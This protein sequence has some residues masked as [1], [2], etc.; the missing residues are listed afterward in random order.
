MSALLRF[1]NKLGKIIHS[2]RH[3]T[4]EIVV[5]EFIRADRCGTLVAVQLKPDLVFAVHCALA[6]QAIALGLICCHDPSGRKLEA[7]PGIEPGL[8]SGA[9]LH[10]VAIPPP[11]HRAGGRD[12]T[13]VS[14][15]D[16]CAL[17]LSYARNI[18]DNNDHPWIV[19]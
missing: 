8:M 14:A 19:C 15:L 5:A 11:G 17:P 10:R 7:Q 2:H 6:T 18:Y 9:P 13:N 3:T 12:R 16:R 1:G 4:D